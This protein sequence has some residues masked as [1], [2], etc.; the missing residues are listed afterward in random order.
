MLK[1]LKK[2]VALSIGLAVVAK[3]KA[4]KE[5]GK[6]GISKKRVKDAVKRI[7]SVALK[8]G[9]R[10]ESVLKKEIEKELKKARPAVKKAIKKRVKKAKCRVKKIL[11]KKRSFKR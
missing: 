2:G 10:I 1:K 9:K 11:K 7:G 4:E 3:K 8:E 5:I 6:K